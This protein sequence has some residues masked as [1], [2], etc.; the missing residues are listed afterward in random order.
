[1]WWVRESTDHSRGGF[2]N[3]DVGKT[4]HDDNFG[5]EY[6]VDYARY[7]DLQDMARD[8]KLYEKI[9]N[10]LATIYVEEFN[11]IELLVRNGFVIFK[12]SVR[13]ETMRKNLE[14][15]IRFIPEVKEV[16]NQLKLF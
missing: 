10:R 9:C 8:T 12:G 2:Q 6:G 4:D 15:E 3:R 14:K 16:I 1:M 11:Q 5:P 13:D 7:S